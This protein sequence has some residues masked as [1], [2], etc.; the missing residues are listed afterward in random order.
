[1]RVAEAPTGAPVEI[2]ASLS[3]GALSEILK[4]ST[5][6]TIK[7][8]MRIGVMATVNQTV[9]FQTAA[10]VATILGVQVRKPKAREESSAGARVSEKADKNATARPPIVT[11]LGHVDHGK[12]TL[13][14][15]IRGTTVASGEAGGITQKIGAYQVESE[16]RKITFIDTPGHQAFTQMRARGAQATDIAV[17]VVAAD[18]GVQP[19]TKEALDHARAAKVPIIVAIN[20][21]DT[22][23]AD[24]N[25]VKQQLA[26]V[27][28][29][30]ESYGG[31][32]VSVE[33]SALKGDGIQDLLEAIL[34]VAD[35]EEIKANADKPGSGVVIESNL[36]KS[37]GPVATVIV[38]SGT[39][40]TGDNIVIG[41]VRGRIRDMIDGFGQSVTEAGPATPI[42]IMGL[43]AVPEPGDV[44]DVVEDERTAR[45]LVE[46]RAKLAAQRGEVRKAP[47][48]AEV[49]R[50]VRTGD[51]KELNLIVKTGSQ[52]SIDA[53]RRV[54]EPLSTDEVQVKIVHAATGLV[55]EMDINLAQSSAGIVVAFETDVQPGALNQADAHGVEIRRY[56][57]IY[58]L[59]EDLMVAISGM[60]TPESRE[61]V[62]GRALVQAVFTVGRRG[63]A[64]GF[65]VNEGKITRGAN[66]RVVRSGKVVVDAPISSLRH[67]KND[68]RDVTL[69]FEGGL[70]LTGFTTFVEGDILE[71][72]ETQ[73][74]A[75]RVVQQ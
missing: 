28:L 49:M 63:Q 40:R 71:A 7:A 50:R 39:V 6:E 37:R 20:K 14:D 18:D 26:E 17:L 54:V 51:V 38:R 52:G 58:R 33:V 60:L 62:L 11:I 48:L 43:D 19:Q 29:I 25:R 9:D 56:N 55:N 36:D 10:Q 4:V 2:P 72:W 13:L 61:V 70:T 42:Q 75:R 59:V 74:T 22:D 45:Q 47:T 73:T 31:N 8:L 5:V 66:V 44:L 35:V 46:T 21:V 3:V 24:V 34:L 30:V 57:V 64:A 27:D 15:T 16:G 23:G 65:R 69:G 12:T 1:M 68:V 41:T 53:V 67:L 32:V